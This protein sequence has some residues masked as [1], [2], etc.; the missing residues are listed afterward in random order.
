MPLR[1][2]GKNKT[3]TYVSASGPGG[4]L[5]PTSVTTDPVT[6]ALTVQFD[7]IKD[8][9]PTESATISI[10]VSPSDPTWAVG[11][12]IHDEADAQ[13]NDS[14]D[15]GGTW[16]TGSASADTDVLPIELTAKSANQSTGD[17]Q[18]TGCGELIGSKWP[19]SYTVTAQN[20]Y[21]NATDNVVITDVLPDGIEYLASTGGTAPTSVTR[22]DTTGQWTLTWNLGTMA[23]SASFTSTY[24]VGIRYDYYG[25]ANGGTN[26]PYNDYDGT[27]PLGTPVADQTSLHNVAD[28][29]CTYLGTP[30][31]DSKDATVIAAYATIRKSVSPGTAHN[32]QTVSFSLTYY[33]SRVLRPERLQH[34]GRGTGRA[35]LY[36]RQREPRARPHRERYA[37]RR[38]DQAD[39][40][41]AGQGALPRRGRAGDHHLRRHGGQHLVGAAAAGPYLDSRGRRHDQRR[42][43]ELRLVR[44]PA[45]AHGHFHRPEFG[46]GGRRRAHPAGGQGG[47]A[48]QRRRPRHLQPLHRP[49]PWAIPYGSG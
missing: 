24:S 32:G 48:G 27:P 20:N 1:L 19:Y 31:S 5:T 41:H 40:E 29:D 30:Y 39:L 4:A 42:R 6:N 47:G 18:A 10:V 13:V 16:R 37:G 8:L 25:T 14:A 22:S 36:R 35:Y 7:D 9:A 21:V 46:L 17:D 45:I 26:R 43:H 11:D 12:V 28:L 3:V 34:S 49:R 38:T 44:Q 2:D 23:A 15:G 33:A